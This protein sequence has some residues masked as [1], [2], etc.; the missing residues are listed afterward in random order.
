MTSLDLG[1]SLL[2][3]AIRFEPDIVTV[4]QKT[5]LV[6]RELGF[7]RQD[8]IRLATAVSEL[9]RN[10]FQ[11]ARTGAIE[12]FFNQEVPQFFYI[13]VRDSGPGISAIKNILDGTYQSKSGMGLGLNGAKKLMDFFDIQTGPKI[14]TTITIGKKIRKFLSTSEAVQLN[15]LITEMASIPASNPFEAL[16]NQNRELSAAL[17]QVRIAK[18]DL[19]KLNSELAETNRAV[20]E[21]YA[22][23]DGRALALSAANVALV[24]ATTEADL[25]N[26]LRVVFFPT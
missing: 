17:E 2:K 7:D 18:E 22:E 20:I 6:A 11:Y 14:G 10:V 24:Q 3:I 25:A 19:S 4:R 26:R 16:Q 13:V 8:Q 23:L 1:E 12:F 15:S 21:L 9:A 5:K